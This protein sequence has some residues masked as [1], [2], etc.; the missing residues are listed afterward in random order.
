MENLAILDIVRTQDEG[1][2]GGAARVFTFFQTRYFMRNLKRL[3]EN[4]A[5]SANQARA[6]NERATTVNSGG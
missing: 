1:A 3:A 6:G 2:P 5:R 4:A